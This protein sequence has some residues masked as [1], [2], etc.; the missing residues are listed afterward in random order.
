M[1]TKAI[2]TICNVL[3]ALIIGWFMKTAKTKDKATITGFTSMILLYAL[4]IVV[5]WWY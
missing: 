1:I 5:I 2:V 3:Y 4:N